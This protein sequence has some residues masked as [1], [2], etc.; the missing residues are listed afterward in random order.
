MDALRAQLSQ[1]AGQCSS[2]QQSVA[3][4]TNATSALV[5]DCA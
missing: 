3:K 5:G 4:S 1:V 2:L